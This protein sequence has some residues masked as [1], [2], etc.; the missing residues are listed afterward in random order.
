MV[1]MKDKI[2]CILVGHREYDPQVIKGRLWE[3][4]DFQQ[5]ALPDFRETHCLRCGEALK[6]LAA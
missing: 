5:Y 2:L 3:D 4:P 6:P 1:D